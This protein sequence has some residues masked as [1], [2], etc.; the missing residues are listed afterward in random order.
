MQVKTISMADIRRCPNFILAPIHY[1]DD[2]TCR[3]DDQTHTEM[4]GWGYAWAPSLGR[5]A[6]A[7]SWGAPYGR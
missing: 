5:W 6:T 1:R 7:D 4:H 2:G 3:C